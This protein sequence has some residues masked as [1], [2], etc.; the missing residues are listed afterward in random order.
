MTHWILIADASGARIFLASA[1]NQP[2][3]LIR[4]YGNPEGRLRSQQLTTDGPGRI[5]KSGAPGTRSATA[6]QTSAHDESAENF[7]RKLASRLKSEFDQGSYTSLAIAAPPHFLGLIRPMLDK[8]V[9]QRLVASLPRDLVH[10][11]AGELP[12]HLD[13]LF[14]P[15]VFA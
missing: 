9:H 15:G 3:E 6:P 7:A 5:S 11:P 10:V 1:L 2:L 4:A 13:S 8:E 14:P 12:P